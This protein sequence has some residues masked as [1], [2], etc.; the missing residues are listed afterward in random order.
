M[1]KSQTQPKAVHNRLWRGLIIQNKRRQKNWPK[2]AAKAAVQA[3]KIAVRATVVMVKAAIAAIKG[4][5]SI[6]AAGGWVAVVV[7]IVICLFGLN[8][9]LTLKNHLFQY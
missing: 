1:T 2:A 8:F 7:I 9:F 4:L 5:V 3:A 6:I